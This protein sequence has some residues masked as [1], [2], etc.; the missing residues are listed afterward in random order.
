M[1]GM[2]EMGIRTI[3]SVFNARSL[4]NGLAMA[5]TLAEA[6]TWPLGVFLRRS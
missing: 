1:E 6:G 4:T 3:S 5:G 2:K